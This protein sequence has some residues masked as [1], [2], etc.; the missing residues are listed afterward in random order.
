MGAFLWRVFFEAL[1]AAWVG[2]TSAQIVLGNLQYFEALAQLLSSLP[3]RAYA[4]YLRWRFIDAL[5]QHLGTER[6][7]SSQCSSKIMH[8]LAACPQCAIGCSSIV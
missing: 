5:V 8:C 7:A 2:S 6:S 4:E 3:P 1:G